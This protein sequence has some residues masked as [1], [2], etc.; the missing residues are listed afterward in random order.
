MV[1]QLEGKICIGC[2]EPTDEVVFERLNGAFGRICAMIVGFD[3]LD[4]ATAGVHESLDCGRGLIVS[5]CK[6][7]FES[8]VVKAVVD[9]G[10]GSHDVVRCG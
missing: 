2:A 8:M 5:N 7:G 1:P 3:K 6:G 4:L 10:K 9:S